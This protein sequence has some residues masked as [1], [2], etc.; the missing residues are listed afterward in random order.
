[1]GGPFKDQNSLLDL[2]DDNDIDYSSFHSLDSYNINNTNDIQLNDSFSYD[3]NLNINPM[4][5]SFIQNQETEIAVRVAFPQNN[6]NNFN[7]LDII[8]DDKTSEVIEDIGRYV[9]VK[10]EEK[11]IKNKK[12]IFNILKITRIRG[13]RSNAYKA[14][15][16]NAKF[17]HS[18]MRDDNIVRKCKIDFTNKVLDFV[19]KI[20]EKYCETLQ[21]N[22][23][24]GAHWLQKIAGKSKTFNT[25]EEN[26]NWL[27]IKLKDYL[28]SQVSTKNKHFEIGHNA[29]EIKKVIE[30]GEMPI[31]IKVLNMD[32]KTL[33]KKYASNEIYIEY[34]IPLETINVKFNEENAKD[35][36]EKN[37]IKQIKHVA[38]NF[39]SIFK[40]K[41]SRRK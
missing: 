35:D 31:L 13:R 12:R 16:E 32:I 3:R 30:S 28:S 10:K 41:N 29:K 26:L 1:M 11:K 37:Y 17:E 34:G 9:I 23:I 20:Y 5:P 8:N 40:N 7:N 19:N 24:R 33:L 14:L 4:V 6:N 25:I 36:E 39:K 27:N 18:K 38:M 21:K 22:S 2:N 15:H